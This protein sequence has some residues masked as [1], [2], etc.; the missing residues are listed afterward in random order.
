LTGTLLESSF[1]SLRHHFIP[2]TQYL[3]HTSNKTAPITE[4]TAQLLRAIRTTIMDCETT[5]HF[6]HSDKRTQQALYGMAKYRHRH[7]QP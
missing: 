2:L 1:V 3:I 4:T 5:S 6:L 7:H